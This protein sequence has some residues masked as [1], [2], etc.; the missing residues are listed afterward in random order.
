MA[1]GSRAG[2]RRPGR[3]VCVAPRGLLPLRHGTMPFMF[4]REGDYTELLI[5]A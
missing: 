3:G 5:P 4:E 2:C 1:L